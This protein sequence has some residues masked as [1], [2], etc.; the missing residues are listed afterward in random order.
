M[1][2]KMISA[3]VMSTTSLILCIPANRFSFVQ[4]AYHP[5]MGTFP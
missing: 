3:D 4:E 1:N 2:I 5:I